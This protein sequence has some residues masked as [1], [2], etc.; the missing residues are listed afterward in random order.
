MTALA[1]LHDID[2]SSL[3]QG[4]AVP[5][6]L[7]RLADGDSS[8]LRDLYRLAPDG[9]D[10]RPWVVWA[11]PFLLDLVTDQARPLR[12]DTLRLVGDLAGADRTWQMAGRTLTAKRTLAQWPAL[13]DLL[14]DED[15]SVRE[16]AAYTIR[17]VYR[18]ISNPTGDLWD[19]FAE[20]PDA[21]VRL[22]LLRTSVITGAV[23]GGYELTKVW[24][25]SVADTDD[26]LRVR[27]SA[28]TELMALYNP[29]PFDVA[30][31][32]ETLL[33]AYR[34]GLNREPEPVVDMA[35]PLLAGAR[36]ATR[37]WTPGYHQVVSAIRAT[38]RDD[39]TAHLD[40]LHEMLAMDAWDAKQDA[41]YEAR[42]LVQR[43]RGPYGPLVARA[44]ELLFDKDAQIRAASLRLLQG[45][46][47]VARPS[48]DAVWATISGAKPF[49]HQGALIPA[50]EMLAGL[51]DDRVLPILERLLDDA[52]DTRDLHQCIAGF[53]VRARGLG[54]TLRRRL[55][56]LRPDLY[57]ER[58]RFDAHRAGLLEALVSVAP[59][60]AADHLLH[61]P[62]DLTGLDRLTR[63]GR[64]SLSRAAEIRTLLTGDDPA[65]SLAAARAIW[66]VA[67]DADDAATVYDQYLDSPAHAV[68]AIDG[69]AE[70]NSR[71]TARAP[72]LSRM[73]KGRSPAA[74]KVAA[75]RALWRIT[76][77]PS[78]ARQL[79][80]IWNDD[81]RL[82]PRIAALWVETGMG[83]YARRYV[84]AELSI[85]PRHNLTKI[86]LGPAE[87][88]D[89]ELLLTDCRRLLTEKPRWSI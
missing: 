7:A 59:S 40:L 85:A 15:T 13:Q 77:N 41:L 36:M 54:R 33:A 35:A 19:R 81:Q 22:T 14:I 5:R 10:V 86:G 17:A 74:V 73:L 58:W 47:E 57:A 68:T 64:A 44:S 8:A 72:R 48:T 62:L 12:G 9:E 18:L 66:F 84:Q 51:R 38:Y 70:L 1:G 16:A 28:L 26:D 23:G 60:E 39:I 30:R 82:R 20:E 69:L 53:G 83:T 6:L 87:V 88:S 50:V 75:A 61:E 34:D 49:I 37:Q 80:P 45:I 11:L 78:S 27:I 56:G 71:A 76:G 4:S 55:R 67:G 65:L 29:P 46:G 3:E 2:W 52:P 63:T 24:L 79:G 21:D 31:A 42:T 32:R 43:L 25:A 89:D